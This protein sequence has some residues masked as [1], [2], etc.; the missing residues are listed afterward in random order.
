[1]CIRDRNIYDASL[2]SARYLCASTTTMSTVEGEQQAYFAYNHDLDYSANVTNAGA[3]Y[4]GLLEVENP[5]FTDA[6][7]RFYL[8][9]AES[10]QVEEDEAAVLLEELADLGLLDW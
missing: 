5:E 7:D 10:S 4:R 9:I 1:M 2:A 6:T 3:R 8:G